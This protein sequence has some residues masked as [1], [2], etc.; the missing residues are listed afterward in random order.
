MTE[1]AQR[2]EALRQKLLLYQ[3]LQAQFEELK[4]QATVLQ[5]RLGEM[6]A[7]RTALADVKSAPEGAQVLIPVG[8]GVF[9]PGRLQRGDLLVDVGAG[10]VASRSPVQAEQALEHRRKEAEALAGNLQQEL[11][12][13]VGKITQLGQELEKELGSR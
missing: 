3:L 12:S 2:E 9:V 11:L 8:S 5:A 4:K 6:E 7:S 13:M 1:K 10:V